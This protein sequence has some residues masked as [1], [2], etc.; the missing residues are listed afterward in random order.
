VSHAA[1]AAAASESVT[2]GCIRM[3]VIGQ[4]PCRDHVKARSF[5]FFCGCDEAGC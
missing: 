4:I 1:S 5:G 3:P 2:T